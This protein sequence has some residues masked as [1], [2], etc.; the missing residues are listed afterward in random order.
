M[1]RIYRRLLHRIGRDPQAA[2]ARRVSLA[3][4]EK[5]LVAARGMIGGGA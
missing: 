5:V 2:L 4:P 3:M 1:A